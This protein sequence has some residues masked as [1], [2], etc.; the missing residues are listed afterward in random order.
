MSVD[1]LIDRLTDCLVERADGKIVET[2]YRKRSSKIKQSDYK[3]WK[4]NWS[5]PEK[6]NYE[7][8]ELSLIHI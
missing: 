5:L 1:I 6:N 8:Y 3:N 2:E 7:I 4:F